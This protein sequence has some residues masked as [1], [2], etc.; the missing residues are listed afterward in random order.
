MHHIY[1]FTHQIINFTHV[2]VDFVRGLAGARAKFEVCWVISKISRAK[3][4]K[5]HGAIGEFDMCS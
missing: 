5:M 2:L 4:L 3:L 1:N